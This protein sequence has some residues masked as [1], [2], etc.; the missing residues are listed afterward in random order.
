MV[1]C[2]YSSALGA[3][4]VPGFLFWVPMDFFVTK[5]LHN[6]K[7]LPGWLLLWGLLSVSLHLFLLLLPGFLPVM[8][9][10]KHQHELQLVAALRANFV[11]QG[12]LLPQVKP[13]QVQVLPSKTP[14]LLPP[15]KA[16]DAAKTLPESEVTSAVDPKL[17]IPPLPQAPA[18]KPSAKRFEPVEPSPAV[19]TPTSR[20]PEAHNFSSNGQESRQPPALDLPDDF[21]DALPR[22]AEN[23]LPVYPQL[24]RRNGWRGEVVLQ[25]SVTRDGKVNHLDIQ[26]SS[27]FR[28]LD[29]AALRAVKDWRFH[30]ARR[31]GHAVVSEV[32]VPVEFHLSQAM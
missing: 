24:A 17:V 31:A 25:V 8:E 10:S 23:P 16:A 4:E 3:E 12:S 19:L 32:L 13:E 7:R 26:H 30:P 18:Q 2:H 1:L 29:R 28:I 27:G 5:F 9:A 11:P 21:R 6:K 14:V 22:Y 20:L 15:P